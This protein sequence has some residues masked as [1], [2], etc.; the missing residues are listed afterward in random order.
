MSTKISIKRKRYKGRDPEE[1]LPWIK[2]VLEQRWKASKA[3][4]IIEIK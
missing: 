1:V 2:E 4:D 3:M